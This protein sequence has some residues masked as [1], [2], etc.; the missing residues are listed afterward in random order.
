LLNRLANI[1]VRKEKAGK[2]DEISSTE[3]DGITADF[4]AVQQ[5]IEQV[6]LPADQATDDMDHL[7]AR[8][9]AALKKAAEEEAR[10]LEAFADTMKLLEAIPTI[11]LQ[12][13]TVQPGQLKVQIGNQAARYFRPDFS[14]KRGKAYVTRKIATEEFGSRAERTLIPQDKKD[15]IEFLRNTGQAQ[16][17]KITNGAITLSGNFYAAESSN[18]KRGAPDTKKPVVLLLTGSHGSAEDQGLDLAKF[19]MSNDCNVLSVNYRGYGGSTDTFPSEQGIMEDAQNMLEYLLAM[20][21][22]SNKIIIH[23]FS[24]GGAVGGMLEAANNEANPGIDFMGA[25]ADRPMTSS[26]DAGKSNSPH[27]GKFAWMGGAAAHISAGA[28]NTK[29]AMRETDTDL[30]RLVT[31]DNDDVNDDAQ[32]L[33]TNLQARSS[34]VGGQDTK[35]PH[36]DSQKMLETNTADLFKILQKGGHQPGTAHPANV[37]EDRK[38]FKKFEARMEQCTRFADQLRPWLAK[39]QNVPHQVEAQRLKVRIEYFQGM[40][41]KIQKSG[42]VDPQ[43]PLLCAVELRKDY[44]RNVRELNAYHGQLD[45]LIQQ[46][47]SGALAPGQPPNQGQIAATLATQKTALQA[48]LVGN[49][50]AQILD[51]LENDT[52]K[53]LDNDVTKQFSLALKRMRAFEELAS[54]KGTLDELVTQLQSIANAVSACLRIFSEKYGEGAKSGSDATDTCRDKANDLAGWI[55]ERFRDIQRLQ[56]VERL[57]GPPAGAAGSLSRQEAQ[58]LLELM[59]RDA[60]LAPAAAA[61]FTEYADQQITEGKDP[62]E[63]AEEGHDKS[64]EQRE[65]LLRVKQEAAAEIS[66]GDKDG[67]CWFYRQMIDGWPLVVFSQA[68]Q[69]EA[70]KCVHP[71]GG[72]AQKLSFTKRTTGLPRRKE[73]EYRGQGAPTEAEMLK[74]L[75]ALPWN[76]ANLKPGETLRQLP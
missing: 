60:S 6:P 52:S 13:P 49:F 51:L 23:G 37:A 50:T 63:L 11:P 44:N 55:E 68:T 9:E 46:L 24:L 73:F 7:E 10:Q 25:V 21:F 27:L 48:T 57:N 41:A 56:L 61:F 66:G 33:R 58:L 26:Y 35:A 74:A 42:I 1:G 47:A 31:S 72:A 70:D 45:N 18:L 62:Y 69:K 67:D 71:N 29:E 16:E 14:D 38:A 20:G 19:Y 32:A 28:F 39:L 4:R 15:E 5:L 43:K 65:T 54:Q 64:E 40:L 53:K 59:G 34:N 17:V 30:P 8:I 3:K 2:H 22:P 36:M 75:N 12:P 76:T